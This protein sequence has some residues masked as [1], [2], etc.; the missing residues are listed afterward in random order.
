MNTKTT[1]K[2]TT[3]C[4]VK[5]DS[6]N[7]STATAKLS[8]FQGAKKAKGGGGGDICSRQ[9]HEPPN[10][11]LLLLDDEHGLTSVDFA[12]TVFTASRVQ[13]VCSIQ[14][15]ERSSTLPGKYAHLP[16]LHRLKEQTSS[17]GGRG[18]T[19]GSRTGDIPKE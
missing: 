19:P 12:W 7:L 1:T 18:T 2:T 13:A 4:H 9:N 8:V 17:S 10:Q 16:V 5:I 11:L 14:F 3:P 6:E 15:S